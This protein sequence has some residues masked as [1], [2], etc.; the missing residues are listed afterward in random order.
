ME[1]EKLSESYYRALAEKTTHTGLQN[2]CKM[3]AVE[4]NH[5][6]YVVRNL[7]K[8]IPAAISQTFIL[9]QARAIFENMR[10]AP[11]RFNFQISELALYQKARD[12]E[13]DSEQFYLNKADEVQEACQKTIFKK[14]AKEENKHFVLLETICDFV[15]KPQ[16]YLENAEF[17]HI[18][19]YA[20][21]VF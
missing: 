10:G 3:L 18:Q 6:Y 9:G 8:N 21:G 19:D 13:R 12:I 15:S 14:L 20:D 4:E 16:R 5:H 7:S 1:Q 11:D 17:T 2:I